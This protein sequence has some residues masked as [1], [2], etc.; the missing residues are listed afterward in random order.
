MTPEQSGSQAREELRGESRAMQIVRQRIRDFGRAEAT[1][2]IGGETGTGKELAARALHASSSR[3]AGPFV[4]VNCAALPHELV[5]S[6]LFG[7][8]RGAFTGAL[9]TRP[10]LFD[11]ARG[12]TLLLDEIGE[13]PRSAQ[14][15]L[16]RVLE[17]G[18]F[19]PLGAVREKQAEARVLAASNRDLAQLCANGEF[20][21]DLYYRLAVLRID[22]PPLRERRAD[23]PSLVQHF[24]AR[25]GCP[26]QAVAP[27][28]MA[29]LLAHGWPGNVR[30]LRSVVERTLL[31][32]SDDVIDAFELEESIETTSPPASQ[33]LG[34]AESMRV[35]LEHRGRLV[36]AAA[37]LGVSPRTL[38]RRLRAGGFSAR[39]L[40]RELALAVR[41]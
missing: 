38:Q 25:A 27:E 6:E 24:I 4:A 21:L 32:V 18:S 37:A 7:S 9:H 14:A 15:K 28:T 16:L 10:G 8:I 19:R 23:I 12:G 1:V 29:R 36:T 5:E 40:R 11:A 30:E 17:A 39:T 22:L 41:P 31:R 2:L 3:A 35:L 20:R 34:S 33:Q 13:L 26:P